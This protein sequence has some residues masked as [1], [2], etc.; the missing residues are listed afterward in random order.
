MTWRGVWGHAPPENNRF[1]K[2]W[3]HQGTL[4]GL[5]TRPLNCSSH[6]RLKALLCM[7]KNR[8]GDVK[9]M[10]GFEYIF[11]QISLLTSR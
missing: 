8:Q 4:E 1:R 3:W 11:D 7:P 2:C 9:L 10:A 6:F 5:Q